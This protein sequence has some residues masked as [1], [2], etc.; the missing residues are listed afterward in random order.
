MMR[1]SRIW[2]DIY[3]V[4]SAEISHPYDCCIYLVDS[5]DGLVLID[6]GAGRSFERIVNNIS[7]LGFAPEKINTVI[8]THSH[9]DHIGSLA[10][11]KQH[12]NVTIM[13]HE[14]DIE[15]IESGEKTGA[16]FYGVD[17]HPC[18][19]DTAITDTESTI[20]TGKYNLNILHIP[21]HTAG[22]VVV[23]VDMSGKRVLFGQ[24]IHGPYEPA[25]GGNP[26]DA[27]DSLKKLIDLNADILCEGHFGIIHPSTEVIRY[28]ENYRN[29]LIEIVNG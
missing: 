23:W 4:G 7:F 13:A 25:L 16:N 15:A 9:I 24:D 22:S 5:G 17:Y 2:K 11:F 3:I 18:K 6:S 29:E 10:A 19:V 27:I 1:P 14:R 26:E 21:G 20:T 28:I 8:A 12:Y